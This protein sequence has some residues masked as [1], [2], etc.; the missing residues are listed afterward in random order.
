MKNNFIGKRLIIYTL[1]LLFVLIP[2]FSCKSIPGSKAAGEDYV[3]EEKISGEELQDTDA[4]NSEN[5][6][7]I[8]ESAP[9]L[10]AA[11]ESKA[12]VSAELPQEFRESAPE[13]KPDIP[14]LL[15][16]IAEL[17]QDPPALPAESTA[18]SLAKPEPVVSGNEPPKPQPTPPPVPVPIPA[19]APVVPTPAPIP[20]PA[21][22]PQPV[23]APVPQPIPQLVPQPAPP[24]AAGEPI[25]PVV[26]K[27]TFA[28][29]PEV[30]KLVLPGRPAPESDDAIFSRVVRAFTGQMVEIPFRG[31]G[32]V[33]LGE[34]GNRRG[35]VYDSR[36]LDVIAGFVE[37]Q[38]FIFRAVSAGIY[39]L[40]FYKQDFIQ[41]LVITDYVQVI[42]GE[43]EDLSPGGRYV[44]RGRVIAEPR[45][46]PAE[47]TPDSAQG[48]QSTV[49]ESA[50]AVPI[51]PAADKK[52][53]VNN[54]LMLAAPDESSAVEFFPQNNLDDY[55]RQAKQEYD[56]GKV[57]QALSTMNTMLRRY[58]LGSDE[59]L[60]LMGQLLEANSS[61]RDVRLAMDYYRR[62]IREYPQSARVPDAQRR[63]AYLERFYFNLR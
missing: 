2:I 25:P 60:W 24:S 48:T 40:K 6:Q 49:L 9:E 37:G 10:S 36:R 30:E 29:R 15:G 20:T 42:V 21:P 39:I 34:L 45:W 14:E 38:S 28:E 23:P 31:T 52:P 16:I 50:P 61:A 1:A 7:I 12:A 27:P 35:I 53:A 55:I 51:T 59:A 63:I 56:A 18:A 26:E 5:E 32:W 33:Y 13:Q 41:D 22:A 17:L 62:L 11:E 19:P 57:E 46:P 58:P 47:Y 43:T 54:E 44:D 4:A 3:S 8:P